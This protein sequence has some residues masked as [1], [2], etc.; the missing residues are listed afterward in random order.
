MAFDVNAFRDA[1]EPWSFTIGRR[2]F[3]GRHVSARTVQKFEQKMAAVKNN[4]AAA[5]HWRWLLRHAFPWRFSYLLY[6]DPVAIIMA[7]EPGAQLEAL[8]DFFACL[9]GRTTSGTLKRPKI[10]GMRSPAPTPTRSA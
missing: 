4:T 5:T 3:V 1:H 9:Q 7:L 6:G 2:T 8:K 10:L